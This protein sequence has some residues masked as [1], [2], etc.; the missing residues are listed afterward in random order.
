MSDELRAALN[1]F[2]NGMA[3]R[4]PKLAGEASR[5]GESRFQGYWEHNLVP[6][7][8]VWISSLQDLDRKMKQYGRVPADD[9]LRKWGTP[10]KWRQSKHEQNRV[11]DQIWKMRER[12]IQGKPVEV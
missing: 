7:Q 5:G 11:S 8:R 12:I 1:T 2:W 4:P 3:K 10:M 6:S 9:L